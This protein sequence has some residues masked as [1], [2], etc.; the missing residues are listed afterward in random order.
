MWRRRGMSGS[1]TE[2]EGMREKR[3]ARWRYE[4]RR[5]LPEVKGTG[6]EDDDMGDGGIERARD[7]GEKKRASVSR[8][9]ANVEWQVLVGVG[10]EGAKS[11]IDVEERRGRRRPS[12]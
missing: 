2:G 3:R 9:Y 7:D 4:T 8:G 10:V 11:G 6:R 5:H 1:R 12:G